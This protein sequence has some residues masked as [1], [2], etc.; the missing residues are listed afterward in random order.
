MAKEKTESSRNHDN[1]GLDL[2]FLPPI[3]LPI[4]F[5]PKTGP[6]HHRGTYPFG[7]VVILL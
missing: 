4:I 3:F 6:S 5:L 7:G 2:F 1:W